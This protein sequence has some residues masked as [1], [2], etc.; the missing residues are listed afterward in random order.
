MEILW[1]DLRYALRTIVRCPAFAAIIVATLGLGI[2]ATTAMFSVLDGVVLKPLRYPSAE[3][4][5]AV[6]TRF[7]DKGDVSLAP[8]AID[9]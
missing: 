7:T 5:V 9:T 3:R 4:L 6:N 8:R 1:L 2:G